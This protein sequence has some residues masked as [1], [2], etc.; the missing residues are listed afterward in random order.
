MRQQNKKTSTEVC[1]MCVCGIIWVSSLPG[2]TRVQDTA[3]VE[4]EN[5]PLGHAT[6]VEDTK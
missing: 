2:G 5:D 1:C 6:H 3:A 4:V